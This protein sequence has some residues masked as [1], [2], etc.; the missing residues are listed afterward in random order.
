LTIDLAFM[1]ER[2]EHLGGELLESYSIGRLSEQESARLEEHVLVCEMCQDRLA[3]A[4]SWVRAVRRAASGLPAPARRIWSP[5]SF[6]RL[7]PV[8]AA[9]TL[10][11]TV[12]VALRFNHGGVVAPVAVILEA[13]RGAGLQVPAQQPLLLRPGLEGLSPQTRYHLQVVDRLGKDVWRADI[14][15]GPAAASGVKMP[16]LS[17]GA[18]F[19]R[20]Y[21]PSR[22]LL[23]EYAVEARV[24]K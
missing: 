12:G 24:Q 10:I 8:L 2:E 1:W 9:L 7:A 21:D 4:D 14:P 20:L 18:Y 16:G 3:E 11:L 6:P 15:G 5:W 19:V 17:P 22:V 23:R 13:T